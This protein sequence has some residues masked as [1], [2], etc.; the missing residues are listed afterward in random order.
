MADMEESSIGS[1]ICDP[2][3]GLEFMGSKWD[4]L[5][6][7]LME[8]TSEADIKRL[9]EYEK[10][11]RLAGRLSKMPDLSQL[12]KFGTEVQEWHREWLVEAYRVLQPGGVIKAFS[13]TRTYHRLAAAMEDAGFVDIHLEAWTY[14]SG[15]PKS[16]NIAL[17]L[18]KR[19]KAIGNRGRAIPMAST[20]FPGE[21]KYSEDGE[22]L[23][24]NIVEAYEPR[25]PEA[26]KWNGWGTAVK[27]AWEPVVVGR[28]P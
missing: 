16:K 6:R 19:A 24:S 27:P 17:F 25:T 22:K 12:S 18:D 15:F 10:E 23:T 8:P 9:E 4:K 11:G 3:Y 5:S 28:K 14:G 21:G 13:A 26:E 2:P 1:V 7:N 20:H